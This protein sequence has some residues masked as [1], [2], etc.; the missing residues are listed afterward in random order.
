MLEH[1]TRHLY[2]SSSICIPYLPPRSNHL[3]WILCLL[4]FV[5]VS[6]FIK[7]GIC[8]WRLD[9]FIQLCFWKSVMS[10]C[11]FHHCIIIN[12]CNY[13]SLDGCLG[14]LH[15]WGGVQKDLPPN[16][17]AYVS[18]SHVRVYCWVIKYMN[19]QLYKLLASSFSKWLN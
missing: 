13:C 7:I 9:F 19:V 3:P 15:L 5:L 6:C 11:V 1:R 2:L 8:V 16:I 10:S 12:G 18:W 17:L 4:F 14:C